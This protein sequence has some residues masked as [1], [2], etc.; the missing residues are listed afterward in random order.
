MSQGPAEQPDTDRR[1]ARAA[2]AGVLLLTLAGSL[3]AAEAEERAAG[4]HRWLAP[5][6]ISAPATSMLA[7]AGIA[8]LA[9]HLFRRRR[10]D[11]ERPPSPR[12]D[13]DWD[14]RIAMWEQ[15][16]GGDRKADARRNADTPDDTD[17]PKH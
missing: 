2:V 7:M 9:L 4:G 16:L 8:G 15:R 3:C 5:S 13:D 12:P 10:A 17:P 1:R 11:K 6:W 14:Q